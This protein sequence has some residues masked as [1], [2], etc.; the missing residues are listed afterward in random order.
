MC[1]IIIVFFKE[2]EKEEEEEEEEKEEE[3]PIKLGPPQTHQGHAPRAR[4]D[5]LCVEREGLHGHTQ[6]HGSTGVLF[7]QDLWADQHG[8]HSVS[9][10]DQDPPPGDGGPR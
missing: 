10:H 9:I 5:H 2:E 3:R 7:S 1:Q 8:R 6:G 4:W